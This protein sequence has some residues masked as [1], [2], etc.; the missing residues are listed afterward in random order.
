M[1]INYLNNKDLLKEIHKS[2]TSFCTFPNP[3]DHAYDVITDNLDNLTDP[4]Y[5]QAAIIARADRLTKEIVDAAKAAGKPVKAD[6]V[7]IDP[8]T[9]TAQDVVF[10]VSTWE[11]IPVAEPKEKIEDDLDEPLLAEL[12]PPVPVKYVKVNFPPFFHYK[13][14]QAMKPAIV[15]KSHWKGDLV[16]G[17]YSRTHGQMTNTLANMFIKLCDRYGTRWNWRSY[18]YNDE[19]RGQALLQLSQIGLQFNEARSQNPF[20]YFTVVAENSF[21]RVLNIE[22]RNQNIRDDIMEING[23]NPSYTRQGQGGEA[24]FED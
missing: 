16:T 1:K 14:D 17:E 22:K 19:M 3:A 8:T 9:L 18:T 4:E 21:T 15:G 6:T 24:H 5:V 10:R 20:A 2:K 11:H 12:T 23:M 7:A 13:L